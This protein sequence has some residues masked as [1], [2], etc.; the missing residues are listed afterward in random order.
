V[1]D[2]F[3]KLG[4]LFGNFTDASGSVLTDLDVDILK[5]V[6]DTGEDFCFNDD[7]SKINGVLGDLG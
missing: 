4:C 7:L 3:G 6:K 5:A 2:K 1:N